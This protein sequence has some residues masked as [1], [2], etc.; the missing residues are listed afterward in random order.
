MSRFVSLVLAAACLA[1]CITE[2]QDT[3]EAT[4][5]ALGWIEGCWET[6]D[7]T[8]Y[9]HWARGHESLI[10]GF[11]TLTNKGDL[12][13]FE[14]MRFQHVDGNWQ[15]AA[16]PR[17]VG[18]TLFDAVEV[19]DLKIVVENPDNDFPQRIVYERVENTLAAQISL[20]DGSNATDWLFGACGD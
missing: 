6:Q 2:A 7:G 4:P 1:A 11:N 5:P 3:P 15:F 20:L 18:P 10:F 16:Y 14:Q 17:G 12:A 9:E 13:F 19:S 8:S